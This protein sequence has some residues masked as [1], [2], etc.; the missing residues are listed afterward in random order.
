MMVNFD[1][2]FSRSITRIIPVHMNDDIYTF[3]IKLDEGD[4]VDFNCEV[5]G[6]PKPDIKWLYNGKE[7][8]QEGRYMIFEQEC[9]HHLEITDIVPED[10]GKYMVEVEN[11]L[12]KATCTAELQVIGNRTFEL[13]FDL[14]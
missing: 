7:L 8:K 12:G 9:L 11:T 10:A 14:K 13:W 3:S 6:E 5:V 4:T 2:I 1:D